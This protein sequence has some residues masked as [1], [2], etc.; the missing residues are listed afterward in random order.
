[1]TQGSTKRAYIALSSYIIIRNEIGI[2]DVFIGV[3]GKYD[4]CAR[5]ETARIGILSKVVECSLD[6]LLFHFTCLIWLVLFCK[7]L[8]WELS[9]LI[10]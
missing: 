10:L 1:M 7:F 2:H 9:C 4:F 6:A 3:A 5:Y 8:A